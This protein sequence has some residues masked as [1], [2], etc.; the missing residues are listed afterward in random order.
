VHAG[1]GH[2]GLHDVDVID[3]PEI[4]EAIKVFGQWPTIP[5]LYVR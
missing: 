2:A 5:Q 4:R 1:R 3:D